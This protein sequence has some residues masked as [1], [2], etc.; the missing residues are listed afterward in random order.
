MMDY[1]FQRLVLLNSAGYERAELPLD[2][3]VSLVAPNNTGKTSLINALQFLLI[4]DRRRMDFSPHDLERSR[5]FYFPN[6]SAYILLEVLLPESGSVVLG[7]VGKGVSHDYEY[8][9]YRGQLNVDDYRR[10]DGCLVTQP[11]LLGHLASRELLAQRFSGTEFTSMVYGN[12]RRVRGEN[13]DFTVFRLDQARHAE[14]FQRVLTRTLRLDK[15]QSKEVKDY[16]LQIFHRDLSDA[17][18]DF[19]QEWDKAFADVNADREQYQA[20]MKQRERICELETLYEE[21]LQ[22]RGKLVHFRPLID[23]ALQDWQTYY[24]SRSAELEQARAGIEQADEQLQ[25]N[26]GEWMVARQRSLQTEEAL[27][28]EHHRQAELERRFALIGQRETLEQGI[29][30]A[31]EA[32][33]AQVALVAGVQ[34]QS[35]DEIVRK[36]SRVM[37]DV[38]RLG[39]ERASLTGNLYQHLQREL[40]EEQ[41]AALNQLFAR[42]VMTLPE[43]GF[44]LNGKQLHLSLEQWLSK[45]CC[46]EL[47]GLDLQLADLPEQHR[48]RSAEEV[49]QELSDLQRQLAHLDEQLRAAEE[50]REAEA[51]KLELER[52][53][54]QAQRDLEAFDELTTLR[55]SSGER[56]QSL[57]DC[58]S[59]LAELDAKLSGVQAEGRR[60]REQLEGIR[61]LQDEL[62]GQHR[63]I[64]ISRDRRS[65]G[66]PL[67]SC[68]PDL[69]QNPWVGRAELA[70]EQMA[71]HLREYQQ[72]CIR[73]LRLESEV[74]GLLAELH[75]GGLTKFQTADDP[76]EEIRLMVEFGRHLPQEFEAIERK[77]RTAVVNVTACLRQLRGSLNDFKAKM[78]QFNQLIGRR[79]LSD[80]SVFKIEPEDEQEL[81]WAIEALI[82]TAEQVD[83]GQ[84]FE[85]FDHGSV[86]D[87]ESLTRAKALLIREGDARGGLAVEHLFRLSFIVGKEGQKPESFADLDGAASNGTVLMAKLVTGLALLHQMQDKRY[88]VRAACYL[89]E[90]LALDGPNQTSL[91]DTAAE[92]GFA[93]IFASPAPLATVRYCVPITRHGGHNHVSRK[94]W[95]EL[96]Q[97]VA[98]A[99]A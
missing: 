14:V 65:D 76:D 60:L 67:F 1:G 55:E 56:E 75:A 96:E 74:R 41:L 62:D 4:I 43:S 68:L 37:Q 38:Q 94:N 29:E 90:A 66:D 81:V 89:D 39:R 31:R 79:R 51:L 71:D 22:L 9:A 40:N 84:S 6:N 2:A 11:E 17:G 70:I 53:Y 36:R 91:I 83:S 44:R 97:R 50:I 13:G 52:D 30:Q 8:F 95:Q 10:D 27:K 33:E 86:L 5:R 45:S 98:G 19:K 15:L 85:L 46:L 7:C 16:L 54:Q 92:F 61:K 42:E 47:P 28:R 34:G 64:C 72:D 49:D 58:R 18:I 77:A 80:L 48:Q 32:Y 12:S 3:S 63:E 87:D 69:L 73:L 93:L 21:R 26:R 23:R 59:T 24:Q 78:R 57:R 82:N 35:P 20:A 88:S 99:G 25:H